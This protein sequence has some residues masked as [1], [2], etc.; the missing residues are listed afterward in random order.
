MAAIPGGGTVVTTL[1]LL[2]EEV[3]MATSGHTQAPGRAGG[4]VSDRSLIATFPKVAKSS[5]WVVGC[6]QI[7]CGSVRG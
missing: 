7:L 5:S 3:V 6:N 4:L 2:A 1:D